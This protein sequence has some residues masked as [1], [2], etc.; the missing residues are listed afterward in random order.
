MFFFVRKYRPF[1]VAVNFQQ[2]VILFESIAVI[3]VGQ[4]AAF[5]LFFGLGIFIFSF[6]GAM[7]GESDSAFGRAFG[8]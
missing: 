5:Y 3:V 4:L 2:Y 1:P 8:C 7:G 6:C